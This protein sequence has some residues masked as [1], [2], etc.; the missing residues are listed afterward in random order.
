VLPARSDPVAHRPVRRDE[1]LDP[2]FLD[3]LDLP[4]VPVT[5]V[6]EPDL[7]LL[8]HTVLG[9]ALQGGVEHR[10][11]MPEVRR[12][13]RDLG[14]QDDLLLVHGRLRVI[15]LAGRGPCVRITLASGSE[16]LITPSGSSGGVN[17]LP[18]PRSTLPFVSR[19]DARQ[20]S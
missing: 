7:G 15:C 10:L 2:A 16:R 11:Q 5:G 9:E 6:S 12:V 13:D 18:L 8:A 14:R 19:D 20:W 1:H 17:G 3:R 4:G